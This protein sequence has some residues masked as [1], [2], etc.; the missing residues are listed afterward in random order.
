MLLPVQNMLSF[1][2]EFNCIEKQHCLDFV[3]FLGD[4][5]VKHFSLSF[6]FFSTLSNIHR[7]PGHAVSWPQVSTNPTPGFGI[8]GKHTGDSR[9][10]FT[11]SCAIQRS[12]PSPFYCKATNTSSLSHTS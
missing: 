6:S 3:E 12:A 7:A 8:C 4:L 1:P 10:L 9:L 5:I 11:F 2:S